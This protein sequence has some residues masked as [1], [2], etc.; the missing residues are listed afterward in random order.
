MFKL[1]LEEAVDGGSGGAGASGAVGSDQ[2]APNIADDIVNPGA[3]QQP[4]GDGGGNAGGSGGDA[5]SWLEALPDDIKKDPSLQM[6][7]DPSSLAKS[8]VNAQK[9]IG[10]DKVVLPGEKSTEEEWNAFY[11]KLG[12]P[13]SPDKYEFKL[14]EGQELDEGFAKG[15]KEAAFKSGLSPKQVAGLAEWYGNAT[16]ASI[17]AQQAAQ[18]NQLRESLQ[19]YTQK[20]GGED[21]FKARVDDARVA[22]RSLANPELTEFL[23][24][25]GLGSRPEMIEF[26][27]NLKGMM[28]ED[29]IRDGTGVSFNGEDP[30]V[31]QKE[32]ESIETKMFAEMNSPNMGSWVEQRNKLYERLNAARSRQG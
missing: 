1:F 8:W 21:K 11:N 9:M 24:T 10:K 17:E 2:T 28:S 19:G 30:S 13:E 31:L 16:K 32:I 22:L 29:K 18:V 20:L 3:S 23:K 27:A 15:F 25:S 7:K 5:K 4:V 26:F 14:P 6:F 12:R